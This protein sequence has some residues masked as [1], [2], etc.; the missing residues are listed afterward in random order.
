MT[1]GPPN[2][3]HEPAAWDDDRLAAAFAARA[4]ATPAIPADIADEV[5]RQLAPQPG[6]R[7][8]PSLAVSAAAVALVVVLGGSLILRQANQG[9]SAQNG[10]ASGSP[11]DSGA[12]MNPVL[13]ALGDP[14]TVT[15][16]LGIRDSEHGDR[17]IVVTGFLSALPPVP[18]PMPLGPANPTLLRCPHTMQWL[19]EHPEQMPATDPPTGPAFHPS[20]ALVD[21]PAVPMPGE[22][23][24]PLP[25]VLMGHFNDR[26]A[27][28]C[29]QLERCRETFMVDRLLNANGTDLPTATDRRVDRATSDLEADV[30]GLIAVAAP[31]AIVESRLLITVADV[32]AIEPILEHD[33][34]IPAWSD[35][36]QLVWSVTT[37]DIRDAVPVARTFMLLDGISWFAEVTADGALMLER[38]APKPSVVAPPVM[39]SADPSAFDAAPDSVLGMPV[40]GVAAVAQG[41]NA[42]D[43]RDEYA[44]AGWYLAP[45]P[46]V[47]C[48][49]PIPILHSL[50]PPCDEARHWLLGDPGLYGVEPGQLRRDPDD[51]PSVLNPLIPVDVPFDVPETWP[52]GAPTP[53]PVV[54]IGHFHDN[55]IQ[56]YHSGSYFVVDALVWTRSSEAAS[57]DWMSRLTTSATE[58]SNDVILRIE[59]LSPADALATWITAVD[60]ADFATLEPSVAMYET[61]EFNSGPP[62]WIARRLIADVDEGRHRLAVERSYTSDQGTRIWWT[63]CPDC[64]LDLGTSLDVR[65]LDENTP[66]VRVFDYNEAIVSVGPAIGLGPL[67]WQQPHG[68]TTDHLRVAKGRTDRE[69]VLRWTSPVDCVGTWEVTVRRVD[70]ERFEGDDVY[71]SPNVREESCEG[72]FVVVRRLVIEFEEPVDIDRI[73]GPSCCG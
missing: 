30:D 36:S 57:I 33:L 46:G 14:I 45:P 44:I 23:E 10:A 38:T 28:L 42:A 24:T 1:A 53:Q 12:P 25:V 19:M 11:S 21:P 50:A 68:N 60:A 15:A 16:A 62:V 61:Q 13:E 8:W 20:F 71:I 56:S 41:R 27:D 49:P 52:G 47:T 18:C 63:E 67:D 72:D 29:D 39:A 48:T 69:V 51:S 3:W 58:D 40:R 70:D 54:V 43:T 32:F 55:R 7:G 59:A 17:E 66:L 64:G 65:D 35:T 9:P 5:L 4:A 6:F 26:R 22:G 73:S 34:V 37:A 31:G 2:R